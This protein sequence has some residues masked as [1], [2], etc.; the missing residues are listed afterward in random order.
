M[1]IYRYKNSPLIDRIEIHTLRSGI[2]QATIIA[3]DTVGADQME[4]LCAEL[5]KAKFS[6]LKDTVDGHTAIQVRGLSQPKNLLIALNKIH[7]VGGE[8][9]KEETP[10]DKKQ[11]H[12]FSDKVKNKALYLSALFYD[13]GNISLII[14][15]IQRGRHN[16]TGF[17]SKDWTEIGTGLAFSVGDVLMT[18][19][20]KDKGDEELKVVDRDLRHHLTQ[21]GIE[22]PIGDALNADSLHKSGAMKATSDWIRDH[23][24]Y[25]KCMS[26]FAGGL[27]M[28]HA[29]SKRNDLGNR[30]T[31]KI[32]AGSLISVA[33]LATFM[34]DKHPAERILDGEKRNS[35]IAE[36]AV[37]NPRAWIARPLAI[38]NNILNLHGAAGSPS[39]LG[40]PKVNGERGDALEAIQK[41][42]EKF[43]LNPDAKNKE[44][45]ALTQ[46]RQHDYAWNALTACSFMVA[47][48]LFGISG[49]KRPRETEDDKAVMNDLVLLSANVLAK[50]PERVSNAAIDET[51]EFVSK[52]AHVKMTKQQVTDAIRG[53]V[54]ELAQ[55][56]WVARTNALPPSLD[57]QLTV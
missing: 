36:R 26:E 46:G 45:L 33:W 25:I 55:S 2:A 28:M 51:A 38:V 20:G 29:G 34:L 7:A 54:A 12:S 5:G 16:G 18:C 47:H 9:T 8:L 21:K 15:G 27:L 6:T 40:F 49:S 24:V 19:Y 30:N 23:I 43:A 14:S 22:I 39:F 44:N 3:K 11:K 13:L 31:K 17:T 50:Q 35:T 32:A 4:A 48:I 42:Q 1:A 57:H 41:A 56:S 52:L 37:N 10:G 53:K